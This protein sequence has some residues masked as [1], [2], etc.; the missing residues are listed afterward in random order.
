MQIPEKFALS[1]LMSEADIEIL[2]KLQLL[3]DRDELRRA[4]LNVF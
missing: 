1:A 3:V 4:A 2:E